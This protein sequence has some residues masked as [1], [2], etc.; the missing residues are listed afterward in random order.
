MKRFTEPKKDL[1]KIQKEL[2]GI[3]KLFRG[4]EKDK[5]LPTFGEFFV[6]CLILGNTECINLKKMYPELH[7][8]LHKWFKKY[9]KNIISYNKLPKVKVK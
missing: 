7:S 4:I 5:E 6:L 2:K 8:K 1:K 3:D 9:K